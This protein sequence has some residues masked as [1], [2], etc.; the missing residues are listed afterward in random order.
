MLAQIPSPPTPSTAL[1]L[2]A[3]VMCLFVGLVLALWGRSRG[4]IML[5]LLLAAGGAACGPLIVRWLPFGAVW[6]VSVAAAAF[7]G[8]LGFLLAKM[9][10][11]I[12]LGAGGAIAAL[13][14]LAA[15]TAGS[16]GEKPVWEYE[17]AEHWWGWCAHTADYMLSWLPALWQH[18]PAA[19]AGCAAVPAVIGVAL[20]M[21]FPQAMVILASSLLGATKMV[22][23]AMLLV[24]A[25][26]DEWAAAWAQNL[27]LP[28]AVGAVAAVLGG[29]V[30]TQAH[31]RAI[32]KTIA[33][34]RLTER[35]DEKLASRAREDAKD[36]A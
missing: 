7:A 10:W 27:Y 34:A 26:R 14:V 28:A 12:L 4:R 24:W 36:R 35:P 6:P 20:G 16:L 21:F 1:L 31:V 19:V 32:P 33:E 5:A 30:Q 29:I 15:L 2:S 25:M 3:G 13:V 9:V 18:S 17:Q 22:A 8:V 11:A 23:G